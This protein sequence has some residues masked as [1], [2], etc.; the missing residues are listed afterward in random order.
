MAK[1]PI[2]I[3]NWQK[4]IGQSPYVGFGEI[5]NLDV[6]SR[7]GVAMINFKAV[8]ASSTT[9][10][11]TPLNMVVS[12]GTTYAI[13]EDSKLYDDDGG[14]AE[15]DGGSD[16]AYKDMGLWKDYL[17]IARSLNFDFYGPLSS[18]PDWD[19]AKHSIDASTYKPVIAAQDNKCY[20][21]NS[22]WVSS[23]FE[24]DGET[25]DPNDPTT[26]TYTKEALNIPTNYGIVK[27]TELG[28][29]LMVLANNDNGNG[30]MF[31][32]DIANS[33]SSFE[34]PVSF[35]DEEIKTAITV[36]NMVYVFTGNEGNIYKTDGV[37]VQW[38]AKLPEHLTG[39]DSNKTSVI[40]PNAI[41]HKGDRIF[42]GTSSGNSDEIAVVWSF[43][44]VTNAIVEEHIVSTGSSTDI[45]DV[46]CLMFN[47]DV[48]KIGWKDATNTEQGVDNISTTKRQAESDDYLGY[49][50]SPF[51]SLG[52]K[53]SKS[54]WRP[55]IRMA[56]PLSSD[57]ISLFY[58]TAENGAWVQIE[59]DW[60]TNNQQTKM[61]KVLP[62]IEMAQFKVIL[63]TAHTTKTPEL[64]EIILHPNG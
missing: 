24:K 51:Y 32:W 55:E 2:V 62:R 21:G 10:T 37:N 16:S 48:L 9:I 15:I 36:N 59:S 17:V 34:N 35:G 47:D 45:L 56:K 60:T 38:L 4:G 29:F 28:R 54:V 53:L 3:N 31:P 25:Y 1:K 58:R 63:Q 23:I 14:W 44:T 5:R 43:N 19:L 41:T 13:D 39:A 40:K 49:I 18:S 52:S 42:F 61:F 6:T 50:I 57:T 46:R 20:I 33:A 8:K 26:Y 12:D 64:L 22:Y 7:P 27:L 30:R 11:D